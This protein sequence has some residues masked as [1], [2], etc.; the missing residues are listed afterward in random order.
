MNRIA[1]SLFCV[2]LF[3]C[4]TPPPLNQPRLKDDVHPLDT[5]EMAKV[6][7]FSWET[8][9]LEIDPSVKLKVGEVVVGG[10]APNAK[11]GVLRR[12]ISIDGA[13]VETGPASLDDVVAE[14]RIEIDQPYVGAGIESMTPNIEGVSPIPMD[15]GSFATPGGITIGFDD[16]KIKDMD[17]DPKT[18]DDQMRVS[19]TVSLDPRVKFV[20][21]TGIVSGK[22]EISVSFIARNT[23]ST[24]VVA[25]AGVTGSHEVSLA[26]VNWAPIDIP[27]GAFHLVLTPEVDFR[28]GAKG[29]VIAKYVGEASATAEAMVGVGYYG[30]G[31]FKPMHDFEVSSTTSSS[32]IAGS[33]NVEVYAGPQVNVLIYK[34]AGPT[35]R[36]LAYGRFAADLANP[37]DRC[38]TFDVGARAEAGFTFKNVPLLSSLVDDYSTELFD[39]PTELAHGECDPSLA[40]LNPEGETFGR[41]YEG[42]KPLDFLA[43]T[44]LA[45]GSVMLSTRDGD[46]WWLSRVRPDGS[47]DWQIFDRGTFSGNA[48]A[49]GID[50]R[51]WVAGTLGGNVPWV[52]RFDLDGNLLWSQLY[53]EGGVVRAILPMEDGGAMMLGDVS[54]M[55]FAFRIDALGI[56][57]W[58]KTYDVN[59]SLRDA[60]RYGDG[61]V[62]VGWTSGAGLGA[63][64]VTRI[65]GD[66]SL[67]WNRRVA[68]AIDRLD[69]VD[70][71][72]QG[73]I[74][75]GGS[76][77]NTGAGF[78]RI[79]AD[80][81]LINAMIIR[82]TQALKPHFIDAVRYVHGGFVASGSVGLF[83]AESAFAVQF[84][85][86]LVPVWAN[87]YDGPNGESFLKMTVNTI[88]TNAGAGWWGWG[89]TERKT[90]KAQ[91]FAVRA[92]TF[93]EAALANG[94]TTAHFDGNFDPPGTVLSPTQTVTELTYETLDLPAVDRGMGLR[95]I[96][97]QPTPMTPDVAITAEA[98]SPK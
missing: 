47:L 59:S 10:I 73:V 67:V 7:S 33:L 34:I 19:G 37:P 62:F 41:A 35:M 36:V 30:G 60:R 26:T 14:G 29:N 69:G 97:D 76:Q 64:S 91:V 8:G 22:T 70:V 31:N 71:D 84:D 98:L 25:G 88:E 43:A 80:G 1:W 12:V 51:L 92:S 65:A 27:L 45:D 94:F 11:Y 15:N 40:G 49:E 93:G 42:P 46:G 75:A 6:Q 68:K 55:A 48:V 16:V 72:P 82:N 9:V 61:A 21:E 32:A 89:Q 50:G 87:V 2:S 13:H 86:Q 23:L 96:N 24:R 4:H 85:D 66:G 57:Q 81:S 83:S 95:N 78:V 56:V 17:G 5:A 18:K 74:G 90:D 38:W 54:A 44:P 52:S 79:A 53:T 28:L 20:F 39:E 77:I 63:S 58:S 3:A